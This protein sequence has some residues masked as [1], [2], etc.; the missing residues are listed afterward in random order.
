MPLL[1]GNVDAVIGVDA[2]RDPHTAALLDRTGALLATTIAGTDQAGHDELL[3]RALEGTGSYGAELAQF[4]ADHGEWAVEI[5][6]TKRPRQARARAK[7]Y[8]RRRACLPPGGWG[9]RRPGSSDQRPSTG[10]WR[11]Q[12]HQQPHQRR[13]RAG[14]VR[15]RRWAVLEQCETRRSPA[16]EHGA[17]GRARTTPALDPA[18]VHR[19]PD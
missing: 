18:P 9:V 13:P 7:R 12:P 6:P 2:Y 11:L 3:A 4:L 15:R 14:A 17:D 1:A 16:P 5:N 8:A 19:S 10:A